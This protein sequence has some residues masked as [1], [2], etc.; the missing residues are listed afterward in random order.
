MYYFLAIFFT[1]DGISLHNFVED[2]NNLTNNCQALASNFNGDTLKCK[3]LEVAY[4]IYTKVFNKNPLLFPIT[5]AVDLNLLNILDNI[6]YD[7]VEF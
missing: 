7:G 3:A 2:P 5:G 1:S 4:E 6:K